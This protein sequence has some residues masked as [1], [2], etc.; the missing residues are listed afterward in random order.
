MTILQILIQ[1]RQGFLSGLVVTMHLCAIIWA[2]GLLG[3]WLL[4]IAEARWRR[5]VAIPGSIASFILSGVPVLVL[6]FWLHYPLQ[7]YLKVVIDPFWTA[8]GVLSLLNIFAVAEVVRGVL[9]DFPKQYLDA[10][11]VCGLSEWDATRYITFPIVLR[12]TLPT[13]LMLQ[14]NMLQM[15]LFASM[16]GVNEIFRVAQS[17]NSI[18]YSPVEIYTGL[19]VF[20]LAVCLPL[21]GL[22]L[23][24]RRRFAWGTSEH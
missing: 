24:L 1:Y 20:F 14:V 8:A 22:A 13:L 16:I 5:F 6:L 7:A 15:S 11:R 19:A 4:G 12:Q 3:G 23:W 10:A 2:V 18:V 21:N 9:V 17:I